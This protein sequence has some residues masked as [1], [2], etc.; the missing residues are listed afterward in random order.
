[1]RYTQK[2]LVVLKY[3]YDE[4]MYLCGACDE[5]ENMSYTNAQD[6]S[7]HFGIS[8]Q[9]AG[10]LISSLY[11]KMAITDTMDSARGSHLNDY[12]INDYKYIAKLYT[13]GEFK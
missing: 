11:A 8:M 9:A 12:V 6:I 2:E 10:G 7:E 4:S 3:M 5:H 13:T 1:M